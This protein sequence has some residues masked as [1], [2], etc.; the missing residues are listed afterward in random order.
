M[1]ELHAATGGAW[2]G[3]KVDDNFITLLSRAVGQKF[4]DTY[5]ETCPQQWL[6]LMINFEKVKRAA[7]PDG[8]STIN[9]QLSWD[10]GQKYSEV[11]GG[12]KIDQVI[13]ENG[14]KL[15]IKFNNGMLI[16]EHK[17][18]KQLF[19]PVLRNITNHIEELLK[20]RKLQPCQYF[21][22]V[23]GFS[24][25]EFLQKAI[26]DKFGG[27]IDILIPSEAQMSVIKGAVLFGHNP[28]EIKSR[29]AR[30]TYG[31]NTVVEFN[32]EIHN[33]LKLKTYDDIDY[34][35]DIFRAFVQQGDEVSIGNVIKRNH[36]P[37]EADQT[38]MDITYYC[39]DGLP[40]SVQYTDDP[41]MQKLAN[42][43]V[44]MPNL[45]GGRDRKVEVSIQFGG[46]EIH[47]SAIDKLT[48]NKAATK[49][50]FFAQ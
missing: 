10:M 5:R 18:V 29:V 37:V 6:Q 13:R 42:I 21:F 1:K 3:T 19:E 49:L 31:Y 11:M 50:D 48:G 16:I 44:D 47:I 26:R 34:C 38:G 39:M 41:G 25:S 27:R 9:L 2:G 43:H 32:A 28:T 17:M 45:E 46:T 23:G 15:G 12:Q 20:D 33:A 22:L 14:G 36:T 40:K 30:K 35:G 4:V 8:K 24:E 7:K